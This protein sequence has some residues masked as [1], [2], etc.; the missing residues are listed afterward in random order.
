MRGFM[1]I[2]LL[3]EVLTS[4]L[5]ELGPAAFQVLRTHAWPVALQ[6]AQA[7][8]ARQQ[9]S[10]QGPLHVT[11]AVCP[12]LLQ[13][14]FSSGWINCLFFQNETVAKART[15]T[16]L[17]LCLINTVVKGTYNLFCEQEQLTCLQKLSILT[18][19][20]SPNKGWFLLS[21]I[22]KKFHWDGLKNSTRSTQPVETLGWSAKTA[23]E[24]N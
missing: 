16:F 3:Y 20:M 21:F 14:A 17:I 10:H 4:Y 1:C 5:Q 18:E 8:V 15:P 13:P 12:T 2:L 7:R 6:A 19:Y 24:I 23:L 9:H 11:D 22:W